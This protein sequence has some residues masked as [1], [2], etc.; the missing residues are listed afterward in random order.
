VFRSPDKSPED[1]VKRR[2]LISL[3]K[4]KIKKEPGL[5]HFIQNGKLLSAD[6]R[7]S[8]SAN[9]STSTVTP[10]PVTLS[11]LLPRILW[12]VQQNSR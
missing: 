11:Q 6:K 10:K 1:C 7:E 8:Q 5:Y 3:L 12:Q 2:E 4:E 9:Y